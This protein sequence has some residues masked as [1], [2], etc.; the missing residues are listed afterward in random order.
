MH[1]SF[2]GAAFE[3]GRRLVFRDLRIEPFLLSNYPVQLASTFPV[4]N[5]LDALY[6]MEE[7]GAP[8]LCWKQ[9]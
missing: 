7:G 3:F 2:I 1:S 4:Q 8:T 6:W 5:D 9:A